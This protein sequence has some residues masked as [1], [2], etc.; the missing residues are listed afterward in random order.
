V[1][2]RLCVGEEKGTGYYTKCDLFA[3]VTVAEHQDL[4]DSDF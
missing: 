1:C 4:T 3:S 2:L